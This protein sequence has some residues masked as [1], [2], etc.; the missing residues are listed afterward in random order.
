MNSGASNGASDNGDAPAPVKRGRGRPSKPM[1]DYDPL[2]GTMSDAAVAMIAGCH[3]HTIA[4]RR[5]AL[6]R[7]PVGRLSKTDIDF[8]CA[9]RT[10]D[11]VAAVADAY[12]VRPDA[13][14]HVQAIHSTDLD[15]SICDDDC[16]AGDDADD[17]DNQG[18]TN[19]HE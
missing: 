16:F 6:G 14:R 5:R 17:A 8:I 19:D 10:Y 11:D 2:I 12:N 18:R 15:G 13:I 1:D 7:L 4:A 3:R 9:A